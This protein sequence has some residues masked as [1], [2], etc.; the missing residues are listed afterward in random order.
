MKK[1]PEDIR[2]YLIELQSEYLNGNIKEEDFNEILKQIYEGIYT[3]ES[4]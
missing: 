1:F 2:L 3:N 4:K